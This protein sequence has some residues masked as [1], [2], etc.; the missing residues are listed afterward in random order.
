MRSNIKWLL[1]ARTNI[2]IQRSV[3]AHVPISTRDG[4][5]LILSQTILCRGTPTCAYVVYVCDICRGEA[6]YPTVGGSAIIEGK[7]NFAVSFCI[8]PSLF[9]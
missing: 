4:D 7:E 9:F 6:H 1:I 8:F 3:R 5:I 2:K